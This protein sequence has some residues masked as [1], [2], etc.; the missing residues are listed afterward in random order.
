MKKHLFLFFIALSFVVQSQE[1]VL[2]RFNYNTGEKYL[3]DMKISQKMGTVMTNDM[4]FVMSQKITAID[5]DTF[6]SEMKI[7]KIVVKVI[8]SGTE[9]NYDSTKNEAELDVTGKMMKSQM[10]PMLK[11]VIKVKSSTLGKEIETKVEPNVLGL[12]N[13]TNQSSN[14]VYPKEAVSIGSSWSMIKSEKGMEMKFVYTVSSIT[15]KLVLLDI[16]GTVG[17]LAKGTIKGI[18]YIDKNSGVTQYSTIDMD[19]SISGQQLSTSLI[20]TVKKQ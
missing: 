19:M 15:S 17:G 2:L 3:L 5:D 1:S 18:M 20:A 10:D 4:A 14:I 7:E 8:Q 11:A 12:N 16:T 6:D 13:M 9:V